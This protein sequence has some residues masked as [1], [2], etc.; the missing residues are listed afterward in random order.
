[1]VSAQ[2]ALPNN[3]GATLLIACGLVASPILLGVPLLFVGL[4]RLKDRNGRRTY[5]H[6][7]P[8]SHPR[9]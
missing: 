6:L 8:L 1:M 3:F 7:F 9:V 5:A 4:S 2:P